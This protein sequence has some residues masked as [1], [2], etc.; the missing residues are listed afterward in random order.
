MRRPTD[1]NS[2][3]NRSRPRTSLQPTIQLRQRTSPT[4][5]Y[6][7]HLRPF[8][9]RFVTNDIQV[10]TSTRHSPTTGPHQTITTRL[11][12]SPS[13]KHLPYT[14]T[15]HTIQ[16]SIHLSILFTTQP[17]STRRVTTKQRSIRHNLQIT[18]TIH[19]RLTTRRR[20]MPTN[21]THQP[22]RII[23]QHLSLT[24]ELSPNTTIYHQR[25]NIRR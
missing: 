23:Y 6:T 18:I 13:T 16:I 11:T 20:C 1:N 24:G 2:R 15:S 4:R 3:H 21:H 17:T 10:P 22:R 5:P 8:T 9:R 19:R 12:H 7:F 25:N 14:I